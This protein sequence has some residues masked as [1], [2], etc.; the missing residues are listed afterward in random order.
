MSEELSTEEQINYLKKYAN[1]V[2]LEDRKALANILI[3][4]GKKNLIVS[5]AEGS[6]LDLDAV[7]VDIIY[8]MYNL[9]SYKLDNKTGNK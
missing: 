3:M 8:K 6:V 2:C 1:T 9:L 7:P 4:H 5:C